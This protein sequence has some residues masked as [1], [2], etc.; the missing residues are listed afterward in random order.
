MYHIKKNAHIYYSINEID[1]YLNNAAAYII[2]GI[3]K[4]DHI[5]FVEN[6]RIF[7]LLQKKLKTHLN[8]Q[9]MNLIHHVNNFDFF[10]LSDGFNPP[11]IV[12][13]L[14]KTLKFNFDKNISF[15][16][17]THV[18]WG[19]QEGILRIIEEFEKE[20]MGRV[21]DMRLLLV[22]AYDSERIP[23]WLNTAL[24]TCHEFIMT[25]DGVVPSNLYIK[26][27]TTLS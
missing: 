27:E 14:T 2:A 8:R 13:Y 17:W 21:S 16:I 25:E 20:A 24:M 1:N 3:E 6:D 4:G 22:C 12:D 5:I 23:D 19:E 15:R 18:E 11:F 10:C 26:S 7:P 9:Q